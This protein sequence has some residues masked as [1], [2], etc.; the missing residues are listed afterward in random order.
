MS[1]GGG[2]GLTGPLSP[3]PTTKNPTA[4]TTN[5]KV[6]LLIESPFRKMEFR[7]ARST[8]PRKKRCF[9]SDRSGAE[10]FY[11]RCCQEK[12]AIA[13]PLAI[14]GQVRE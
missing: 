13:S 8:Q 9:T 6:R 11:S 4:N 14:L 1:A 2:L 12:L 10:P 5:S 7:K 3:Q